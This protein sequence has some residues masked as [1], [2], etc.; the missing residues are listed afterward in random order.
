MPPQSGRGFKLSPEAHARPELLAA[1]E[2]EDDDDDAKHPPTANHTTPQGSHS[3][4]TQTPN[5]T[6]S[7]GVTNHWWGEFG[8]DGRA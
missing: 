2:E 7:R 4:Q 5:D 3:K 8:W 6:A 1:T